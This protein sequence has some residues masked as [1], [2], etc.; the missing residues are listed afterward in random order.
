MVVSHVFS[1]A[2]KMTNQMRKRL[3]SV[4]SSFSNVKNN[5]N[6]RRQ[7]S[8]TGR[9]IPKNH[10]QKHP[11]EFAA[12]PPTSAP[13]TL[14]F[15]IFAGN[16]LDHPTMSQPMVLTMSRSYNTSPAR[17]SWRRH[18]LL[19]SRSFVTKVC[20]INVFFPVPVS[21]IQNTRK[22]DVNVSS[23][24][25]I[26]VTRTIQ[27]RLMCSY[28]RSTK[29]ML[30]TKTFSRSSRRGVWSHLT[31]QHSQGKSNCHFTLNTLT[32]WIH[33]Q[34]TQF[35]IEVSIFYNPS[36]SMATNS[37]YSMT[38]DVV[39]SSYPKRQSNYSVRSLTKRTAIQRVLAV[40]AICQW[41]QLE[42]TLSLYHYTM[43]VPSHYQDSVSTK[44]HQSSPSTNWRKLKRTS[45]ITTNQPEEQR[46]FQNF[47]HLSEGR[48]IS[49]SE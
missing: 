48:F 3:G 38:P 24:V 7:P 44:S 1:Q 16:Q 12:T 42:R 11:E 34:K 6:N 49:W 45:T 32:W 21:M 10:H 37:T 14:R 17:C 28:A 9:R 33:L 5:S 36:K 20:A 2:S 13:K 18:L 26:Q 43:G 4:C 41:S 19:V 15:A 29:M 35:K 25:R 30:P 39:I 40:S 8:T 46:S 27:P 47:N 23:S 31:Y 22:D